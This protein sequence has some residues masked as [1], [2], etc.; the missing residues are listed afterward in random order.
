MIESGDCLSA[1]MSGFELVLG[2]SV[3]IGHR[4][5]KKLGINLRPGITG[6]A[7]LKYRLEDE[8]ISEY[9]AVCLGLSVLRGYGG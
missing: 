1:W 4:D 9:V 8:M 5:H 7:T 6:P 3:V 2:V